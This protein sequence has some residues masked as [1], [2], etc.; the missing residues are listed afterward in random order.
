MVESRR[1]ANDFAVYEAL[2]RTVERLGASVIYDGL[3]EDGEGRFHP[4][5]LETGEDPTIYIGRSCYDRIDQPTPF[6]N[7]Y[8]CENLPKPDLR[9]ETATLAHECGHFLSWQGRTPR[10]EWN[11]YFSAA[12]VRDNAWSRVREE[13]SRSEYNDELRAAARKALTGAE[14]RLIVAEEERAWTIG[15]EI[16]ESVGFEDFDYYEERRRRGLHFHRYRL[17]LEDLW[18]DDLPPGGH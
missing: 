8:G 3:L 17:G 4:D 11:V 6:R 10:E 7:R 18:E 5:P 13:G 15:R 2:W 14:L 16:L 12:R 9:C 1:M